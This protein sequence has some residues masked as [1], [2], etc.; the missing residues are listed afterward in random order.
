[1]PIA[2]AAPSAGLIRGDHGRGGG[3][4]RARRR[5]AGCGRE[6][7]GGHG[8]RYRRRDGCEPDNR[9]GPPRC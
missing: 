8:E 1:M 9:R 4:E 7:G 3:G 2:A 5:K 6:H